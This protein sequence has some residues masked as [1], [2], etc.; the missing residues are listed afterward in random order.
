M[1]VTIYPRAKAV[2]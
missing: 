1:L 2:R